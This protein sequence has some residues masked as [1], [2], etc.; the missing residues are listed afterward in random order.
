MIGVPVQPTAIPHQSRLLL[1][2]S[3]RI[4]VSIIAG[5]RGAFPSLFHLTVGMLI[6]RNKG[7]QKESSVVFERYSSEQITLNKRTANVED[8][9]YQSSS[10]LNFFSFLILREKPCLLGPSHICAEVT[11]LVHRLS[12]TFKDTGCTQ[13]YTCVMLIKCRNNSVHHLLAFHVGALVTFINQR[14]SRTFF[15]LPSPDGRCCCTQGVR[16]STFVT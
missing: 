2:P 12:E 13:G 5:R 7:R 1:L 15:L 11:W 14:T 6:C 16:T 8:S 9:L 4:F 10:H 3:E